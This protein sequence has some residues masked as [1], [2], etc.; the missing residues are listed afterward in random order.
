[1]NDDM[2]VPGDLQ[3]VTVVAG[4]LSATVCGLSE[5]SGLKTEYRSLP[6]WRAA[7]D[8]TLPSDSASLDTMDDG[9]SSVPDA[10]TQLNLRQDSTHI[11]LVIH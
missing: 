5:E 4:G 9:A 11:L 6:S 3:S 8:K 10:G 2:V 7:S 1:M